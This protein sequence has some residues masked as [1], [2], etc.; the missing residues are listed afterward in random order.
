MGIKIQPVYGV[1]CFSLNEPTW[2]IHLLSCN[3]C[4]SCLYLCVSI[5]S[6]LVLLTSLLCIMGG[7]AGGGSVSLAVDVSDR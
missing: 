6:S 5:F 2:L 7:L 4:E 3:V 1:M